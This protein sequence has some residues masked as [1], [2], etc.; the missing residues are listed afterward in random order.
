MKMGTIKG[1]KLLAAV[2]NWSFITRSSSESWPSLVQRFL[3]GE[4]RGPD[5]VDAE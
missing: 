3:L 1:S 4:E 2:T 5:S